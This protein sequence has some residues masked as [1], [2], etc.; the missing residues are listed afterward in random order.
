MYSKEN[1]KEEFTAAFAILY[2]LYPSLESKELLDSASLK[3]IVP[4]HKNPD[5]TGNRSAYVHDYSYQPISRSGKEI[6]SHIDFKAKFPN[7]YL[8]EVKVLDIK[9]NQMAKTFINVDKRTNYNYQNF[10]IETQVKG[11]PVFR[12]TLKSQEVFTILC[13]DPD[14]STL[15]VKCYK[16]QFP[17]ALPPFSLQGQKPFRYDHD[18]SFVYSTLGRSDSNRTTFRLQKEGFYHFQIDTVTREGLTLFKFYDDFPKVTSVKQLIDPLRYISTKQEYEEMVRHKNKKIAVDNFWIRATGNPDRG[19]KI[20]REYYNRVQD[21]NE[22]FTS[23][24]E[25]W[26]T[27]RGMIYIVY[28]PPDVV[29]KTS[30]SESWVYGEEGNLMSLNFTF[31]KVNNPFTDNDYILNRSPIYKS[32][33]YVAVEAWRQGIIY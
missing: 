18:S 25:G 7:T 12:N 23:Y 32:S 6:I 5:F 30:F 33:W 8:L 22:Y 2:K 13:N 21:A 11:I 20:I 1:D 24:L 17:I 3:I 27:D 26:K 28:G 29:Y 10:L 4:A 9:R 16:R 19:K 14:I 15:F 31:V